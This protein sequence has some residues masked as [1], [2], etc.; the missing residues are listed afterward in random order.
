MQHDN[1]AP[2]SPSSLEE[3]RLRLEE[4]RLSH[5]ESFPK[6]WLPTIVTLSLGVVAACFSYVQHANAELDARER[7][8]EIKAQNEREWGMRTVDIYFEKQHLFDFSKDPERAGSNLRVLITV[9]PDIVANVLESEQSRLPTPG[10][11]SD[12]KR[13]EGLAAI[14]EVQDALRE[15]RGSPS[16]TEVSS[17]NSD[18]TVYIQYPEGS[19]QLAEIVRASLQTLGYRV[20]GIDEVSN[21][22]DRF[23]VRYYREEQE[24]RANDLAK[25]LAQALGEPAGSPTAKMLQS[26]RQLPGG[27]LEVWLPQR[28]EASP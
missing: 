25:Q 8:S 24:T 19:Q 7:N 3:R 5:E 23:E 17:K 9:A 18:F 15:A 21:A 16:P 12:L 20:P 1:E 14:A 4:R 22:P 10:R 27:V 6:K 28:S 2:A 13:I 26:R 11:D